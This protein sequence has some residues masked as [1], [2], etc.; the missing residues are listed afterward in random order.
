MLSVAGAKGAAGR[1]GIYPDRR[2]GRV[3]VEGTGGVVGRI[4]VRSA[5]RGEGDR[6]GGT[7]RLWLRRVGLLI[8]YAFAFRAFH[9]VAAYWGGNFF[10]SLLYPA[11]GLRLAALWLAGAR[12]TGAIVLAEVAGQIA[13]RAIDL[14]SSMALDQALG[15][16]RAALPY[17]AIVAA[18]RW[19][20]RRGIGGLSDEVMTFAL[21]AILGPI[22]SAMFALVTAPLMPGATYFQ[23]I[24][25]TLVATSAHL[26][27]DLLGVLLVTPTLVWLYRAWQAGGWPRHALPPRARLAEA[28]LLL[29]IAWS[30]SL[31]LDRAGLGLQLTP[32]MLAT[33]WIGLRCGRATA[34][35][36]ILA[37]ALLALPASAGDG[38][39]AIRFTLHLEL[40]AMV[41]IGYLA[42]SYA[43][44]QCRAQSEIARR[45]R[46]LFQAERLKTLR[47]MSVA[48][49]HEISQPLS[50]LAV[51]ARHLATIGAQP[52]G[53]RAE[54]AESA[55][56]IGRKVAMLADLVRRLRQFG[57]RSPGQ[58]A[59][60]PVEGLLADAATLVEPE[61]RRLPIRL[62]RE[63]AD[64]DWV[65]LGHEVEL[66]QA[67]VNLLRNAI[68]VTAA[69]DI[70]LCAAA[71]P[72]TLRITIDN[73]APAVPLETP[74]MGM[75]LLITREIVAAHGGHLHRETVSGR[76]RAS[77]LLGRVDEHG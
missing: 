10:F 22:G 16:A 31:T 72:G 48:V 7:A 32:V 2:A 54:I 73:P 45:D 15:V 1:S 47:A 49:I 37:S 51:E 44:A 18:V 70:F 42:G 67:I 75:G 38:E 40:A 30:T 26:V 34:W 20:Q 43:D 57:G 39:V 19:L 50:T 60:L 6:Q 36:T 77:I 76:V 35:V 46:L 11:A 52:D 17:G 21:V 29:A 74:G 23:P 41:T 14:H 5:V 63:A 8:A 59:R 62:H 53:D 27:G 24:A 3:A 33:A 4:R 25:S 55:G 61:L 68:A 66:V 9:V 64:P 65:L 71:G 28:A 56:L 69:G 58:A 13:F 12:W